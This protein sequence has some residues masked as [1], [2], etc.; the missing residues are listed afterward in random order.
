[1]QEVLITIVGFVVAFIGAMSG[2]GA[3]L[4][5]LLALLSFGLPINQA[6]AT[7]KAGDLGFFI[8]A[9]RNFN[10]AKKIK[11]KVLL[12]IIGTNLVGATLGTFAIARLDTDILKKIIIGVLIVLIL[13]TLLKKK[14]ATTERPAKRYWPLVYLGTSV[15]WG[16]LGAGTGLLSMMALMYFRG[17]NALQAMA[18]S[19]YANLFGQTLSVGILLFTDLIDPRYAFFLF[20]GNTLGAHF[21]SKIA[22]KKGNEFVRYMMLLLVTVTVIRLVFS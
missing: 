8:P 14:Y 3:G 7:N 6:I 12:P 5:S 17:F 19:F 2:G 1:M 22:I 15:S 10:R 4:L 9:I 21:G 13:S 20:V 18:H 11:K 16:A